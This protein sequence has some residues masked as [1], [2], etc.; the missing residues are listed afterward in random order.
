MRLPGSDKSLKCKELS[1]CTVVSRCLGQ[2]QRWPQVLDNL[3][4]QEYNAVHFTPI[5]E[6]G[7]SFSHYSIADQTEISDYFFHDDVEERKSA[8]EEVVGLSKEQKFAKVR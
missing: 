1:I 5:Q 6:Y 2:I 8:T 7:E 3:K 4:E